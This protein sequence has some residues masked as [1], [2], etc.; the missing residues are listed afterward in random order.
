VYVRTTTLPLNT[1]LNLTFV[2][3]KTTM[4]V[5][6]NG[7]LN[8]TMTSSTSATWPVPNSKNIDV[9]NPTGENWRWNWS[10]ATSGNI[11]MYVSDMYFWPVA[12]SASDLLP[13]FGAVYINHRL[14][15]LQISLLS[16]KSYGEPRTITWNRGTLLSVA[17]TTTEI[18]TKTVNMN[19]IPAVLTTPNKYSISFD[20]FINGS[21][22]AD[23]TCILRNSS[24]ALNIYVSTVSGVNRLFIEH[25]LGVTTT[26]TFSAT[27]DDYF[28]NS[29][30]FNVICTVDNTVA[31]V[32]I[33]ST[34]VSST[35]FSEPSLSG[36]PGPAPYSPVPAPQTVVIAV[37]NRGDGNR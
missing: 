32:Y 22:T 30:W 13:V 37:D 33:N 36:S 14:S 18:G 35:T 28:K 2:V 34:L 9:N 20:L 6:I 27:S 7:I 29:I 15:P 16:G 26:T 4:T 10:S 12:L 21:L 31:N 24:D 8:G 23:K 1:W 17:S 11:G 5:Y 3:N 19:V 25:P